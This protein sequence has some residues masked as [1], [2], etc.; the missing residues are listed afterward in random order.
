MRSQSTLIN[1]PARTL[2]EARR[3]FD[4]RM[5]ETPGLAPLRNVVMLPEFDPLYDLD[6]MRIDVTRRVNIPPD[7]GSRHVLKRDQVQSENNEPQQVVIPRDLDVVEQPVVFI[8]AIWPHYGHFVTDGMSK[9]WA[10]DRV[11]DLPLLMQARPPVRSHGCNYIDEVHARLKLVER[12]LLMPSRP[13]LFRKVLAAKAAFQHTFRLYDCH[14]NPHLK[15]A[16]SILAEDGA[17]ASGPKKVY[18]TRSR[19]KA[20]ERKANEEV[21]LERRL[22]KE[23]FEIVAPEQVAFADQVRMFNSAQW[24]AGMIGS[25]FHTCLFARPNPDRVLFMMAWDK[26]NPRYLMIDEITAQR[27]FYVNCV[28]V[29]SV[30]SRERVSE[31][32]ID[33]DRALAGMDEAGAFR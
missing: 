27:S 25:A 7:I 30:D 26:L 19:L 18:L 17:A 28:A 29:K 32:A 1:Y 2:D 4:V 31:T 12:G 8:G 9:L 5:N 11:P 15:V 21:E 16:D 24:V 6:G 20:R 22:R 33:V 3:R 10:I 13:T 23:G 14:Q